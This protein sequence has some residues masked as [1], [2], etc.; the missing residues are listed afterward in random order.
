LVSLPNSANNGGFIH[1]RVRHATT[2]TATHCNTLPTIEDR[3]IDHCVHTQYAK[4]CA[5]Q[6]T[7]LQHTQA[8]RHCCALQHTATHCNTLPTPQTLCNTPQHSVT[9]CN[10]PQHSAPHCSTVTLQHTAVTPKHVQHESEPHV[11]LPGGALV[12]CNNTPRRTE[13]SSARKFIN[14]IK[15]NGD[16]EGEAEFRSQALSMLPFRIAATSHYVI[17]PIP[18]HAMG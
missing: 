18:C 16:I 10:T 9:L 15:D 14:V 5:T 2:H 8:A 11:C 3:Q 1:F 13:Q 7:T 6:C 4:P 17:P 12:Y